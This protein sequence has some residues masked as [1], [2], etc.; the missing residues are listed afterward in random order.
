VS[1]DSDQTDLSARFEHFQESVSEG[2]ILLIESC[3]GDLIQ[4]ILLEQKEEE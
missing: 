1:H 4:A 3:L 2:E